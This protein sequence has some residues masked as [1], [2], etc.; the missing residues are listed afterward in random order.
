MAC[1]EVSVN[2]TSMV[3]FACP[4][5]TSADLIT[6]DVD[7]MSRNDLHVKAVCSRSRGCRNAITMLNA[8]RGT[9]VVAVVVVDDD[10][11]EDFLLRGFFL[12]R[13]F[14]ESSLSSSSSVS[15]CSV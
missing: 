10:V 6:M 1:L 8:S 2:N 14:I 5:W 15:F 12:A 11:D 7:T 13:G 9:E 4:P 3:D